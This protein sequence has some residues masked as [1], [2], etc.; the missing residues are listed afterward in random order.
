MISSP[1]H[2]RFSHANEAFITGTCTSMQPRCITATAVNGLTLVA[3][4][5][6]IAHS[7]LHPKPGRP[8]H[9]D[10][11]MEELYANAVDDLNTSEDDVKS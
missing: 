4:D 11:P 2:V 6:T 9:R 3:L 7:L 8:A 10:R 5:I 1:P